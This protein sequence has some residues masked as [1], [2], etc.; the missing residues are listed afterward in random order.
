MADTFCK[1]PSVL[2]A[3]LITKSSTVYLTGS[4]RARKKKKRKKQWSGREKKQMSYHAKNGRAKMLPRSVTAVRSD[5]YFCYLSI[6]EHIYCTALG[7]G[8]GRRS[9]LRLRSGLRSPGLHQWCR[10]RRR[11]PQ[12]SFST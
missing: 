6:R 9:L 2:H 11:R 10:S 1:I 8:Q 3:T 5:Y 12:A 4:K 7:G